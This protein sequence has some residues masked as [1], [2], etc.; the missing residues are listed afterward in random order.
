VTPP[1]AA[2][3]HVILREDSA[4]IVGVIVIVGIEMVSIYILDGEYQ[5]FN[6]W[7]FNNLLNYISAKK[8]LFYILYRN[9]IVHKQITNKIMITTKKTLNSFLV[10]GYS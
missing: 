4:V 7:V 9:E 8:N 10:D 2:L 3:S 6:R 1:H 5:N